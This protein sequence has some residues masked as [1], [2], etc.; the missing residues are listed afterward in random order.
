MASLAGISVAFIAGNYAFE[1]FASPVL[2]G[3]PL[4]LILISYGGGVNLPLRL[5]APLA[6]AMLG[7]V[8]AWLTYAMDLGYFEPPQ[9]TWTTTEK[10]WPFPWGLVLQDGSSWPLFAA[11]ADSKTWSY[12]AVI[13]PLALQNVVG[14]FANT[15]AANSIGDMYE[16]RHV[17][18]SVGCYNML[19]A[20]FGCPFP[21]TVFIG[22]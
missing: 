15:E 11:I 10:W 13:I 2:G 21:V 4:M 7:L 19:G 8:L 18:V 6:A 9:S 12:A 17:L 22:H 16:V 3:I 1:I 20:L 5:P 14:D